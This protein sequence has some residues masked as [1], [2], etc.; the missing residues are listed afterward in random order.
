MIIG[1]PKNLDEVAIFSTPEVEELVKGM[2]ELVKS[3]TPLEVPAAIP[4][5]QLARITSTLRTF[6]DFA[7]DLADSENG[8]LEAFQETA[9]TLL[10][11]YEQSEG[12]EEVK[13]SSSSRLIIPE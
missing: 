3:G 4:L 7:K 6:R 1:A 5:I 2:T 8:T 13:L 12:E 10:G 11:G 9:Q